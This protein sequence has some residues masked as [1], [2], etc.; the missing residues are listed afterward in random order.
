MKA[1]GAV[2]TLTA[3]LSSVPAHSFATLGGDASSVQ[4][5]VA[6]LNGASRVFSVSG[7]TVYEITVPSGTSIREYVSPAGAV[8]A[9]SWQGPVLPNLRQVLGS[10]FAQYVEASKAQAPGVRP[11]AVR[12]PGFVLE[13]A[14]SM[15]AFSGKA[16][17]PQLLPPGVA[18]DAIK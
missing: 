13:S 6:A 2:L 1:K 9:V 7:S 5:D 12:Q 3:I 10:Y 11:L 16:Y 15:R 4:A 17:L 14:G 8:Y 18:A